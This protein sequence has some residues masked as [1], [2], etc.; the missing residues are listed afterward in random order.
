M[1]TQLAKFGFSVNDNPQSSTL[2][3]ADQQNEPIVELLSEFGTGLNA[4]TSHP[5][6]KP[7][8]AVSS[9]GPSGGSAGAGPHMFVPMDVQDDP[10]PGEKIVQLLRAK[11]PSADVEPKVERIPTKKMP[12]HRSS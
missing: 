8:E 7:V 9:S 10:A 4:S 11:W 6:P 12:D 2:S 3:I 1:K 5:K